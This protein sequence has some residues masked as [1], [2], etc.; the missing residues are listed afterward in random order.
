[1]YGERKE[2]KGTPK[3]VHNDIRCVYTIFVFL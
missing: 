3:R 2:E 1:M